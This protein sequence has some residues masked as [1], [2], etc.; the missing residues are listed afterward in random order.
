MQRKSRK[1][2]SSSAHPGILDDQKRAQDRRRRESMIDAEEDV[3]FWKEE[4]RTTRKKL[5][6]LPELEDSEDA[7]ARAER[8]TIEEDLKR[9]LL[10][11]RSNRASAQERSCLE[12]AMSAGARGRRCRAETNLK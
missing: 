2:A 3:D 10:A 5:D 4:F 12:R 9:R 11:A 7:A 8:Q 6:T 1:N